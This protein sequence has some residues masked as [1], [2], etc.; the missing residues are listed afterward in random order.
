MLKAMENTIVFSLNRLVGKRQS[1][2]ETLPTVMLKGKVL[3]LTLVLRK[4]YL[5]AME[6]TIVF[7]LRL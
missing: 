2:A 5:K 1:L 7:S 4:G 6:N 3:C